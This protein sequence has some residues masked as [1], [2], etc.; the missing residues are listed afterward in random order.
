M[1]STGINNHNWQ[2][3]LGRI[4]QQIQNNDVYGAVDLRALDEGAWETPSGWDGFARS[5]IRWLPGGISSET[6]DDDFDD[7]PGNLD[8]DLRW[9]TDLV[10]GNETVDLNSDGELQIDLPNFGAVMGAW[11]RSQWITRQGFDVQIQYD[12]SSSAGHLAHAFLGIGATTAFPSMLVG[13]GAKPRLPGPGWDFVFFVQNGLGSL[14]FHGLAPAWS[15]TGYLRITRYKEPG[16]SN[17]Y[18]TNY[19]YK[20]MATG[21]TWN[22]LYQASTDADH[23]YDQYVYAGAYGPDAGGPGAAVDIQLDNFT[24]SGPTTYD[25]KASWYTAAGIEPVSD[26]FLGSDLDTTKWTT[27]AS[28]HVLLGEI[29]QDDGIWMAEDYTSY[30]GATTTMSCISSFYMTGDFDVAVRVETPSWPVFTPLTGEQ[31]F[32]SFR[33]VNAAGQYVEIQRY[34]D[35]SYDDHCVVNHSLGVGPT[36]MSD[37]WTN[38][39]VRLKRVG[40][41]VFCAVKPDGDEWEWESVSGYA[42]AGMYVVLEKLTTNVGAWD[43]VPC[44]KTF[45][46]NPVKRANYAPFPADALAVLS[47]GTL[48]LNEFSIL[49]ASDEDY[50]CWMRFNQWWDGA[51]LATSNVIPGS[52][53][54]THAVR[55]VFA[56]PSELGRYVLSTALGWVEINFPQDVAYFYQV[57]Q[58]YTYQGALAEANDRRGYAGAAAYNCPAAFNAKKYFKVEHDGLWYEVFVEYGGVTVNRT[59]GTSAV[60]LDTALSPWGI[61][62]LDACMANDTL[63][64][65]IE[66][67]MTAQNEVVVYHAVGEKGTELAWQSASDMVFNTASVPPVGSAATG[68]NAVDA[69]A[70]AVNQHLLGVA[71]DGGAWVVTVQT[72]D[73]ASSSTKSYGIYGSGRQ[74]ELLGGREVDECQ[75]VRFAPDG[76]QLVVAQGNLVTRFGGTTVIELQSNTRIYWGDDSCLWF[77][78]TNE[79]NMEL[80]DSLITQHYDAVRWV[81]VQCLS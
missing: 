36:F 79:C 48:L 72:D 37:D 27:L 20:T 4:V 58:R 1:G 54:A 31:L 45:I 64:V 63:Y 28:P 29:W 6:P 5:G 14:A 61:E 23:T 10:L 66:D 26:D 46:S 33:V 75:G 44:F 3:K 62:I 52:N 41:T 21:A 35:G 67:L 38:A 12:L 22:L 76:T 80:R 47:R 16:F 13:V 25:N 24:V 74:Y 9:A 73:Y 50:P 49:S 53:A 70:I 34:R 32:L 11:V 18:Y 78:W 8:D 59:D 19:Y 30:P 56:D 55:S 77:D 17:L 43:F 2:Y 57:A 65:L 7:G 39:W 81:G 40:N 68:W 71:T 42:P 51:S 60:L 15:T 69:V